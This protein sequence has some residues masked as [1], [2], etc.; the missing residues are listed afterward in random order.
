[1]F[2]KK[3]G[4][5]FLSL[6]LALTC[7]SAFAAGSGTKLNDFTVRTINGKSFTLSEALKDHDLVLINLW[8]TWCPPCKAEFPYLQEAWA[9]NQDRV[10]VI[11]LSVEPTDSNSTLQ[12][13]A[14]SM[15]LTFPIAGIGNTGLDS[16][17][18]SGVPTTVVV[19]SE[20][21]VVSVEI[22]AKFSVQEFQNLFDQYL[23]GNVSHH[24]F[25]FQHA[26]IRRGNRPRSGFNP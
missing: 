11:A 19:N 22:G 3:A 21:N 12:S 9:K 20:G 5:L 4:A 7:I 2:L 10:A 23:P 26:F 6:L 16:F 8:A 17:A 15:G 1:M 24:P 14:R 18:S 13:Y 25:D